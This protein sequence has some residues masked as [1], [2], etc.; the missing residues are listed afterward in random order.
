MRIS[1]SWHQQLGVNAM[2]DQQAKL[3]QTQMKLS[4]GKKILT[5]SED[6]AAAARLLDLDQV[7]KQT[8][9][10]QDNIVM[11][12]QRLTLEESNLQSVVDVLHRV[13]QLTVQGLNDTNT[14]IDRAAIAAELDELNGHLLGI[15]NTKNA[16]G[17]YIFAGYATG[18]QPYRKGPTFDPSLVPGSPVTSYPYFGDPNQRELQIGPSRFVT[19]GNFG[20]QVFGKS[21]VAAT[22][23]APLDPAQ[24][25]V[26][27][28]LFEIIDKL[29]V[30]LRDNAP[31]DVSLAELDQALDRVVSVET[32]VGARMHALDRQESTNDDYILDMKTVASEIG[33][34][35]Y[36][37]AISQFN[38]Q[39]VSLQAA[40]QAYTKVQNLSLFNYL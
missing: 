6:P 27:R 40:Q 23:I 22:D 19:D 36:A 7:T 1:T 35:D 14:Q 26:P 21:D 38:L 25:Q 8:E 24:A 5:P 10:Y 34:L 16:N 15:A 31:Q 13:R 11:A 20:E 28:N 30:S 12:R 18:T 37:E 4:V 9:Q 29:S 17:E 2:L 3:S 39:N 33:D 32:T